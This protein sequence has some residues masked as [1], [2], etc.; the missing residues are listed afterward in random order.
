MEIKNLELIKKIIETVYIPDE[1]GEDLD[2]GISDTMLELED[3]IIDFK[4][5]TVR[6]GATKC[7]IIPKNS[8]VVIKIP[9]RG[10]YYEPEDEDENECEKIFYQYSEANDIEYSNFF[11][12]SGEEDNYC[13]NEYYKYKMAEAAGLS[14]FFAPIDTL[15]NSFGDVFYIQ[16][17]ITPLAE[18]YSKRNIADASRD[19]YDS[20]N[21]SI[22]FIADSTWMKEVIEWYGE[23]KAI[24]FF[25]FIHDYEISD[26]HY[27]NLAYNA[28]GAPVLFDLAGFRD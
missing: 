10:H 13:I 26:L 8:N 27:G 19:V 7:V 6:Y 12:Y 9:M 28:E 15:T 1:L 17:K 2:S 11:S 24:N 4:D 20:L 14:E 22:K 25:T 18:S 5:V 23:E 3:S 16:E 21:Y